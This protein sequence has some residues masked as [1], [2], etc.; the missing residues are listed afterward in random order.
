MRLFIN[1]TTLVSVTVSLQNQHWLFGGC[2]TGF[3]WKYSQL[4]TLTP[5]L[6]AKAETN[7]PWGYELL[8]NSHFCPSYMWMHSTKNHTVWQINNKDASSLYASN[9]NS[10]VCVMKTGLLLVASYVLNLCHFRL[11]QCTLSSV[12]HKHMSTF[13]CFFNYTF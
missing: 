12:S 2:Q 3:W 4:M 1:L 7:I 9:F 10:S 8:Q 5:F 6:S 13:F 11:T